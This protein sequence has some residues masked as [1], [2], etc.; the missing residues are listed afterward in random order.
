MKK[1]LAVLCAIMICI[2]AITACGK[3]QEDGD[4]RVAPSGANINQG[5]VVEYKLDLEDG[6][7]TVDVDTDSSM[8]HLNETANGK[9]KLTVKDGEGILHITLVSKKIVNLFPGY[10]EDAEKEGAVLIEPT[11]DEVTYEDGTTDEVYG[12]DIPV[13]EMSFNVA[14]IGTHDNWYDHT[15]TLTN[16]VKED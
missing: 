11:L 5:P 9:G 8:F 4:G 16:P 12:F 2:L 7:Y 3:K 10:A 1:I 13:T 6:V 14:I 15:I